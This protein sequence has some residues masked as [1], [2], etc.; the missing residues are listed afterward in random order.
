MR[1]PRLFFNHS[2]PELLVIC[3]YMRRRAQVIISKALQSGLDRMLKMLGSQSV[4][5]GLDKIWTPKSLR[6]QMHRK[7]YI[8]SLNVVNL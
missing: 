5:A 4:T 6:S 3:G 2:H 7:Q 8:M 1:V